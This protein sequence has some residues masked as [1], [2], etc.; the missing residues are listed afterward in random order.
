MS[1]TSIYRDEHAALGALIKEF[2]VLLEVNKVPAQ[3]AECRKVLSN[4]A[5]KLRIHLAT[6][7][8]LLYPRAAQSTDQS[9]RDLAARFQQDMGP[10]A[11]TFK[12]YSD[13]WLLPKDIA[14]QAATFVTESR[15]VIQALTD[16]IRRENTEFYVALDKAG[17]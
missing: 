1:V 16:R 8:K 6:E 7:D 17:P 15:K 10:L 4:L 9:L 3:A 13:R 14:S 2:E 5:G 11:Q 12:A